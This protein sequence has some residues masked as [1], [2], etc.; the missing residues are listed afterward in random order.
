MVKVDSDLN[1][2][3]PDWAPLKFKDEKT[4]KTIPDDEKVY[5]NAFK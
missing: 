1:H 4:F 3:H 2:A 5:L